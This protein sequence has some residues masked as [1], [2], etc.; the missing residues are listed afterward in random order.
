VYLSLLLSVTHINTSNGTVQRM[1]CSLAPL[2]WAAWP[3][4]DLT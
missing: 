4:V 1:H 2:L 3:G